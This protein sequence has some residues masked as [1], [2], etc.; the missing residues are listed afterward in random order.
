MYSIMNN[1]KGMEEFMGSVLQF[2][3]PTVLQN[4]QTITCSSMAHFLYKET[5]LTAVI[6][7]AY[8]PD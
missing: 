8:D 5:M 6:S 4:K 2:I 1:I 3:L 7:V